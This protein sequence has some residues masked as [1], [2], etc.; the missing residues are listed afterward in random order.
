VATIRIIF[1]APGE[2]GAYRNAWQAVSPGGDLFG[3]PIYIDFVVEAQD[4]NS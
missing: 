1:I 2:A 3:D 4:T